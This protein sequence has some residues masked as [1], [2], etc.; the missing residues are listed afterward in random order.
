MDPIDTFYSVMEHLLNLFTGSI[1]H[2]NFGQCT[3]NITGIILK[4][5]KMEGISSCNTLSIPSGGA[6]TSD[7]LEYLLQNPNLFCLN[8]NCAVRGSFQFVKV[9]SKSL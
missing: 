2:V 7:L 8:I 6:I 4:L 5:L 1:H 3:P 9:N